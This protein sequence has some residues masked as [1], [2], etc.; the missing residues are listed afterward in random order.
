MIA[1]A[2]DARMG[3]HGGSDGP[4]PQ[5]AAERTDLAWDRS[6][7]ALMA[8]G[9]LVARGITGGP[10]T[11]GRTV[12]GLVIVALAAVLAGLGAWQRHR[13]RTIGPGGYRTARTSDLAPL[14]AGACTIG[15]VA[16]LL[17]A[18]WPA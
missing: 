18:F 14:A 15:A 10:V 1:G 12:T 9:A 4:Q 3:D 11:G 6:W 2:G 8:C 17:G 13:R 16:F 7:L 5:L